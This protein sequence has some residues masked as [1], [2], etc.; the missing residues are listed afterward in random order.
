MDLHYQAFDIDDNLLFMS[1]KIHMEKLVGDIW[2]PTDISS[3]EFA[4][5]R[6]DTV[7]WRTNL[8]SFT[9]FGDKGPLGSNA[10]LND[11]KYAINHRLFAPSWKA[12]LKCLKSGYIFALITARGLEP[13]TLR[14]GVEYI[15]DNVLKPREKDEMYAHCLKFIYLFTGDEYDRIP[16]GQFSKT[17]LIRNYLDKCF[18][19]GVTSDSFKDEFALGDASKPEISKDLALKYFSHIAHKYSNMIS[20]NKVT[21]SF[22]DDDIG[23]VDHI[24]KMFKNE[25]SL[26]YPIEYN[27]FN[28]NANKLKKKVIS[29]SSSPGLESSVLPFMKWSNLTTKI[30]PEDFNKNLVKTDLELYKQ[31]AYRRRS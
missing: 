12:F 18:F 4:I 3:A 7:N 24:E 31:F 20:A 5:I 8:E 2:L 30:S 28:S 21:L 17:H 23:T 25:L 22:S 9:D 19:Y 10:F 13:E 15:I 27:L 16:R 26:K 6:S 29:E 11:M 1:T 14:M